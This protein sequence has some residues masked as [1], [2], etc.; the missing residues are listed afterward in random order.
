MEPLL[1]FTHYLTDHDKSAEPLCES[2]FLAETSSDTLSSLS[3]VYFNYAN[4]FQGISKA[5][6]SHLTSLGTTPIPSQGSS[7][8]CS[9]NSWGQRSPPLHKLPVIQD[10]YHLAAKFDCELQQAIHKEI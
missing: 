3:D 1:K 8:F 10:L 2:V 6:E 9:Q 4:S 5:D 7:L